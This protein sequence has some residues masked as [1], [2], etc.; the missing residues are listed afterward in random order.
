MIDIILFLARPSEDLFWRFSTE[1]KSE[2]DYL[3]NF[4]DCF[5][6]VRLR[7]GRWRWRRWLRGGAFT[8]ANIR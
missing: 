3:G 8:C 4:G 5:G 2:Q 6:F 7:W 1:V